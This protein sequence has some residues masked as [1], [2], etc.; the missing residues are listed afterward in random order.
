MASRSSPA[1][2][3]S[4]RSSRPSSSCRRGRCRRANLAA[5]MDATALKKRVIE[6]V[7]ARSK[8]LDD[9]AL[10]IHAQPELAVEERFA[11]SALIDA[12]AAEGTKVERGAGGLETAFVA[13]AGTGAPLVALLGEYDAL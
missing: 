2:S 7:D 4:P 6:R 3:S 12:L 11:A 5:P 13:D 8:S 10:R 9:V 1:R